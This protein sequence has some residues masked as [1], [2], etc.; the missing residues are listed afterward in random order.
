MASS[1]KPSKSAPVQ[2]GHRV[3]STPATRKADPMDGYSDKMTNE[4]CKKD[5]VDW[6]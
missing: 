2:S 4:P 5:E 6:R 1:N 3:T